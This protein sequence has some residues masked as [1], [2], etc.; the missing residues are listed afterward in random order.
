M[1]QLIIFILFY[2]LYAVFQLFQRRMSGGN[3]KP[4]PKP[5]PKAKRPA[6]QRG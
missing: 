6:M 2:I 5:D 1:E 3:K 4:Q